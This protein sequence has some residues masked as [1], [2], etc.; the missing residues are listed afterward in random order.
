MNPFDQA[1]FQ[2]KQ[3]PPGA[4]W[5][6]LLLMVLCLV[7]MVC[8]GC[9][10]ADKRPPIVFAPVNP[11][12][13]AVTTRV[14]QAKAST[15]KASDS[16]SRAVQIVERIIVAPGQEVELERL[17]LELSTTIEQL[18][19]T[20]EFLENANTQIGTLAS[21]VEDCKRWGIEQ[22]E[23]YRA[24]YNNSQ[25]ERSRADTEHKVAFRNGRERDVFVTFAALVAAAFALSAIRPL[26][27]KIPFPPL[28][29]LA[30]MAGAPLVAFGLVFFALRLAVKTI[31]TLTT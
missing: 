18:K 27:W 9:A 6:M 3:R 19:F 22:Q 20:R 12:V 25:T 11:D 7:M 29:P 13:A 21:Q 16:A 4:F 1:D 17:K 10:K 31:V 28:G 14:T 24:E 30:V 23:L 2:R 26:L 15:V 5:L 8:S